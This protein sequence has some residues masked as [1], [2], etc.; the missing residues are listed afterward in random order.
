MIITRNRD[1]VKFTVALEG[2]L[3]VLTSRD[4]LDLV[5][6]ELEDVKELIFDL[7][8]LNYT[9]SAGLRVFLT[10]QQIMEEQGHMTVKHANEAVMDIFEATGFVDILEL[11]D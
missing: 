8:K 2:E 6:N 5:Q 10:A 3:D 4:L 9:S 1:G 11:E 7:K